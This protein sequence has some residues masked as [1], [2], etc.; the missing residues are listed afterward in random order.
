MYYIISYDGKLTGIEKKYTK[1]AVDIQVTLN[2][3]VVSLSRK[4]VNTN[5]ML[6]LKEVTLI[7]GKL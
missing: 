1:R 3:F 4:N 7:E 5:G 2:I 6:I